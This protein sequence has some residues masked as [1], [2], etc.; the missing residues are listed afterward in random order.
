MLAC[1]LPGTGLPYTRAAAANLAATAAG[2]ADKRADIEQRRTVSFNVALN[3][4]HEITPYGELYGLHPREFV[5]DRHLGVVPS[6]DHH[7][8]VDV[9]AT[10][11]VREQ[12]KRG[13]GYL[14]H[15]GDGQ[16]ARDGSDS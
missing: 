16:D 4:V 6:G 13:D 14:P 9:L 8:F 15:D 1:K 2:F 11:Q 10:A 5:F 3:E 7:G 12:A